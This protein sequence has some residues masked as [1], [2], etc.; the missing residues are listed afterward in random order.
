MDV[1]AYLARIG[2]EAPV[3][4]TLEALEQLQRAHL[5]AV[6]F[7]N[8]DVF[9]RR[10]VS[11][12]PSWS[13]PKILQRGR[14][15][16]RYELNGAFATLLEGHA[17]KDRPWSSSTVRPTRSVVP[18]RCGPARPSSAQG[19]SSL[20]REAVPASA[21]STDI[22]TPVRSNGTPWLASRT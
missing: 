10:G 22:P 5:T 14:G 12:E 21:S 17:C 20:N 7:E 13:V 6:Q 19:L 4:L 2:I 18:L 3:E 11:T 8:L 9:Y 1:G 15:R 16:W